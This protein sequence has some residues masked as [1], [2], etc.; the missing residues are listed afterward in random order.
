MTLEVFSTSFFLLFSSYLELCLLVL[1]RSI[2]VDYP[3]FHL[4]AFHLIFSIPGY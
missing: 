2:L 4:R 3:D 1:E